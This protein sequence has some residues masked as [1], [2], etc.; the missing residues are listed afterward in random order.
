MY[1]KYPHRGWKFKIIPT[2]TPGLRYSRDLVAPTWKLNAHIID[3]TGD[4]KQVSELIREEVELQ[5]QTGDEFGLEGKIKYIPDNPF[6]DP[7]TKEG[8]KFVPE[9]LD[10][11]FKEIADWY[12]N[13]IPSY[14][15]GDFEQLIGTTNSRPASSNREDKP[16]PTDDPGAPVRNAPEERRAERRRDREFTG[17]DPR[18]P[19][20]PP[21]VQGPLAG[22]PL[23][24]PIVQ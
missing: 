5:A 17:S 4:V 10:K 8:N 1:F 11:R 18:Q 6:S 16:D 3:D 9:E 23:P 20:R 21:L 2:G 13:L 24:F 12:N 14:L 22:P 15:E 7:V 19:G